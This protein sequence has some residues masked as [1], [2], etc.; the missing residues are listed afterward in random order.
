M[1]KVR[2]IIGCVFAFLALLGTHAVS[3]QGNDLVISFVSPHDAD[4]AV[5]RFTDDDVIVSPRTVPKNAPLLVFLP[6]TNGSPQT[7]KRFLA[8]AASDGYRSIA[9]TYDNANAVNVICQSDP[10]PSCSELVRRKRVYGV[11][12][13]PLIDDRPQ[14]S[15]VNRL[16]KIL[17][18]LNAKRPSEGWDTYLSN[19][20]PDWSR[21]A[22]GGHSQGAG[23]AAFIAKEHDV[24]RVLLFSSP[25]DF[26]R[27]TGLSPWLRAPSATPPDRWFAAYHI[28]EPMAE[29]Y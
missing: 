24:A 22:V 10:H 12:D 15:I 1:L 19:G 26:Q 28:R 25:W 13:T 11:N 20:E 23:M 29:L 27:A 17:E 14:E 21:I 6:G 3:A 18:Y 7:L 8:V 4:A 9:L 16:I 5:T 2:A